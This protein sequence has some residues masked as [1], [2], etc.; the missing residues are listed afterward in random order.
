MYSVVVSVA[1]VFFHFHA[2]D[3]DSPRDMTDAIAKLRRLGRCEVTVLACAPLPLEEPW[4]C[5]MHRGLWHD[6]LF[7]LDA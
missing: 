5:P 4:D 1:R 7:A 2:D 3:Y 6:A